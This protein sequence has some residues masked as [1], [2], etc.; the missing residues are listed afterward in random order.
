MQHTIQ[1][2]IDAEEAWKQIISKQEEE[3][4][5]SNLSEQ[6][7]LTWKLKKIEDEKEE[8]Y[9]AQSAELKREMKD[10]FTNSLKPFEQEQ[11]LIRNIDTESEIQQVYDYFIQTL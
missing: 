6:Q 10:M 7:S 2:I 4:K 9:K 8:E 3:N 1:S 5:K 11:Q